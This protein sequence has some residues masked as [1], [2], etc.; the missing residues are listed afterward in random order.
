MTDNQD[1]VYDQDKGMMRP[2]YKGRVRS[3]SLSSPKAKPPGGEGEVVE[4]WEGG[5]F[6]GY[7]KTKPDRKNCKQPF[8]GG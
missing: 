2:K 1:Q 6:V 3:F 8:L 4:V 7:E 5:R